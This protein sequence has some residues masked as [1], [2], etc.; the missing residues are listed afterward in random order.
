LA[1]PCDAPRRITLLSLPR[2]TRHKVVARGSAQREEAVSPI[3][4]L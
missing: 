1:L 2:E 4:N 3:H